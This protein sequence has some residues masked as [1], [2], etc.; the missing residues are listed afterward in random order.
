MYNKYVAADYIH[1]NPAGEVTDREKEFA[2]MTSGVQTF[3]AIEPIELPY[4]RIRLFNGNAAIV[5][6]HY[7]V[8]GNDHGKIFSMQV[9]TLATWIKRRGNW[10]IVAFQ[11]TS[12]A[13]PFEK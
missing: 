2:D 3:S 13:K 11:V 1:T 7:K 6:T 9:L 5:T 8:S 10:Q 12:V 4:D